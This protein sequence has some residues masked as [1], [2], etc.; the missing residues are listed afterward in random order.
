MQVRALCSVYSQDTRWLWAA[1]TIPDCPQGAEEENKAATE[2]V[3]NCTMKQSRLGDRRGRREK[4][5]ARRMRVDSEI[6]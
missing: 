3:A 5:I 1:V 6:D 4:E 2:R